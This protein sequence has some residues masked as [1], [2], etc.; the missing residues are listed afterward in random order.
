MKLEA[1]LTTGFVIRRQ[2][3]FIS[4]DR[5]MNLP[6]LRVGSGIRNQLSI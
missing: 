3:I 5:L 1:T 4:A 6:V 2:I